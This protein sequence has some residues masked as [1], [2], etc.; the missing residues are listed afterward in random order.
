MHYSIVFFCDMKLILLQ[1]KQILSPMLKA[2]GQ[3]MQ[4]PFM[5]MEE[6]VQLQFLTDKVVIPDEVYQALAKI[7][8]GLKDE[9]IRPSD[10]RFK[11]SLSVLQAKAVINQRQVVQVDDLTILEHILWE[12][13]D[14]KD[15]VSSI[16]GNHAYDDVTQTLYSLQNEANEVFYSI[17]QDQ[18]PEVEMEA[19]QK[20]K[21]IVADL[22]KLKSHNQSRE[23]DI[24]VLL[25]KVTSMQHEI[26]DRILEPCYFDNLNEKRWSTSVFFKM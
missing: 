14:Q 22:N 11:Q 26:L 16:I 23:D 25:D 10:R 20:M 1:M 6:L 8:V 19:T 24:D 18:S 12:K 15:A 21:A 17:L 3:T 2:A 13:V 7:R 9:G 5:T 4:M